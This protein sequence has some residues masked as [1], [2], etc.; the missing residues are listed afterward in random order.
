[1]SILSTICK[2][3]AF[4]LKVFKLIVN[5]V[6]EAVKLVLKA[7][8][9]VLDTLLEAIDDKLFNGSGIM[10]VGLGLALYLFLTRKKEE[11]KEPKPAVP[12][13]ITKELVSE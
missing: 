5:A 9:D 11:G 4:V 6:A 12:S 7:V 13:G 10:W 2:I 8:V 1:M 3:F